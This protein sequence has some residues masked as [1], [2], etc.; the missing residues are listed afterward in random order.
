[1]PHQPGFKSPMVPLALEEATL[2]DVGRAEDSGTVVFC[3]VNTASPTA[4]HGVS[5]DGYSVLPWKARFW[6]SSA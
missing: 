1:M 3:R 6:M 2:T 5:V 4:T